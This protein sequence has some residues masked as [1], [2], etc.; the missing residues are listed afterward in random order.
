MKYFPLFLAAILLWAPMHA[1]AQQE[2]QPISFK[3]NLRTT[4]TPLTA[5][6]QRLNKS[7]AMTPIWS[8]DFSSPSNWVISKD[9]TTSDN[10]VI[11]T[12][13]PLHTLDRIKSTTASNG[14]ALFDSDK[15]CSRKQIAFISTAN[16]IDLSSHPYV[17]L[18]FQQNYGKFYDSTFVSISTDGTT[19]Y[20]QKVNAEYNNNDFSNNPENVSVN[21]SGI[22]GGKKTVW[23]RFSYYS[24]TPST[25][26]DTLCGYSWQVDDVALY[27]IPQNDIT[28]NKA[29]VEVGPSLFYSQIPKT[30][31]DSV[32]FLA[33]VSNTGTAKQTGVKLNVN[34]SDGNKVVY[35]Q[36]SFVIDTVHY[37]ETDTFAILK[38]YF[39][40]SALV[41]ASYTFTL[42]AT[43]KELDADSTN[44]ILTQRFSI[45]DS[46]YARDKGD[47]VNAGYTSPNIYKGGE[48]DASVMGILYGIVKDDMASSV[49]VYIDSLTSLNTSLNAIIYEVTAVN[50]STTPAFTQILSSD[51]YV[52]SSIAKKGKWVHLPLKKN[53]HEILSSQK[54]YLVAIQTYDVAPKSDGIPAKRIL[55]KSDISTKQRGY[56][57]WVYLSTPQIYNG[58]SYNWVV[59]KDLPFIRL[60]LHKN[61]VG[62]S[63][64]N[65][66]SALTVQQNQPNPSGVGT[67]IRYN[68]GMA[69]NV[70]LEVIDMIG[71]RVF[72]SNEGMK[73]AGEQVI[74]LNTSEL[75]PGV[76]FYTLRAGGNA[77]TKRMLV[78]D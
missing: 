71:R 4:G 60:N 26:K 20:R 37:L 51:F 33:L 50:G 55:F 24:I 75:A 74:H 63:E 70:Q 46:I 42:K 35:N 49:S 57:T 65:R 34:V 16:P 73:A 67:A 27:D 76:Y 78:R 28:L 56:V 31:I 14:F 1:I 2:A 52:V 47:L 30:Q 22:A 32:R 3:K 77:I 10:W 45:T 25:A 19:F 21:I 17:K 7:E 43:Q 13:P 29:F 11:G 61:T 66:I 68:L 54:T 9:P 72:A 58:Q 18:N 36:D 38:N 44:N 69:A 59:T 62:I 53:G 64:L 39:L 40:P 15:L 12:T 41:N 23:L 6:S 8:D 48:M 5:P